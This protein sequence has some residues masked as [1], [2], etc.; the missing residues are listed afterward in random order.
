[1]TDKAAAAT[2]P[3]NW[4]AMNTEVR[5]ITSLRPY[6]R[7]AREHS[8]EQVEQLCALMR[9]FGW[10]YAVLVD[11]DDVII[12]GHHGRLEAAVKLGFTHAPVIVARG[13]SVAQKKAYRIADNQVALNSTWAPD[14][15]K[16]ELDDLDELS[17]DLGTLGF[18]DMQLVSFRAGSAGAGGNR[19][20]DAVPEAPSASVSRPGDVWICGRHRIMCGDSTKPADV[21]KLTAGRAIDMFLGDPPYCSGGFQEAGKSAGSVGTR[22]TEMVANDTLSTRGYMALMKAAVPV[23][24]AGVVY[25]FTDWRMWINLFDVVESSG[26]GVRNM[27]VWDK[28]TPGMGAGWRMQHELVMCGVRVKSPFNPKK[29][30]GNVIQSK[31]TGNKLHATEKPV[32][33][34]ES[35]ITVT[36]MARTVADG[37]CGSGG[38]IIACETTGRSGFGM[39]LTPRYVDV[40]VIRWQNFAKGQA[41]LEGDGRTFDAIAQERLGGG[42]RAESAPAK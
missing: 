10:T 42:Q 19:D 26:Y 30:Q 35:I 5:A 12:A 14:L 31:R 6:P 17:F 18:G 38:V 27:I 7:N 20:P 33:L 28:G 39:E 24:G 11:E 23:Y 25:V 1:M 40:S 29:A 2:L 22:G 3:G 36:D 32:D 4:P 21:A 15:L 34:L 37:F 16:I 9:E 41:T 8:D 13:W